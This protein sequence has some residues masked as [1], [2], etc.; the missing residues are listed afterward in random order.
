MATGVATAA[1]W[2][3]YAVFWMVTLVLGVVDVIAVRQTVERVY[4]LLG[5]NP[6]GFAVTSHTATILL[7]LGWLVL[8]FWTEGA[9]RNGVRDG[10]LWRRFATVTLFQL[11]PLGLLLWR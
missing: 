3:A 5:L 2:V 11:L 10:R 4:A 9:Y 1:A 7:G 8:V 6:W